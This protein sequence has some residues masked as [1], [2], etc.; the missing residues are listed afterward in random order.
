MEKNSSVLTDI[1]TDFYESLSEF[2]EE[3]NIRYGKESSDQKK[4]LIND[5][6]QNIKKIAD[7]IYEQREKKILLLAISSIRGGNP[8]L[9]NM[10]S[11]E[12]DLFDS[13]YQK[14]IDSREKIIKKNKT[15]HKKEDSKLTEEGKTTQTKKEESKKTDSI[16]ARVTKEIPEFIGT[17][18]KRYNLRKNDVLSLSEDMGKTLEKRG[19]IDKVDYLP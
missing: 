15:E 17:D 7:N 8:D 5:E 1:P 3:L 9:K 16:I 18:E 6:M 10:I 12:K 13:V 14:M 19:V 2:I 4:T 11:F